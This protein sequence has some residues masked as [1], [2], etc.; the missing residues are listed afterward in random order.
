MNYVS[1]WHMK[2]M[3]YIEFPDKVSRISEGARQMMRLTRHERMVVMRFFA[4]YGLL[5]ATL[6]LSVDS[7]VMT[8]YA[9]FAGSRLPASEVYTRDG[10]ASLVFGLSVLPLVLP[11]IARWV[12]L[13]GVVYALVGVGIMWPL[14]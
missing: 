1:L 7:Y 8:T 4:W 5:V 10:L 9:D 11:G 3:E 6:C 12:R 2:C 13:F 14:I